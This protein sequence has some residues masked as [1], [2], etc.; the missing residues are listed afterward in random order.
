MAG[1]SHADGYSKVKSFQQ[2]PSGCSGKSVVCSFEHADAC[3]MSG[4]NGLQCEP[5]HYGGERGLGG[6]L[7]FRSQ[8]PKNTIMPPIKP[9]MIAA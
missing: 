6:Q 7:T 9:V 3:R 2:D 8:D 5:G 1:S 4:A